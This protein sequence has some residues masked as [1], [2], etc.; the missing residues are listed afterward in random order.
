MLLFIFVIVF[1]FKKTSMNTYYVAL[2]SDDSSSS[3]DEY[4]YNTLSDSLH[5]PK[6]FGVQKS[7]NHLTDDLNVTLCNALDAVTL[8]KTNKDLS[9]EISSLVNRKYP[10]PE[11]IWKWHSPKLE[12]F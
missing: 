2:W 10:S 11:A 6:A 4:C 9:Q 3:D 5:L 1:S 12:V 7:V 8:L